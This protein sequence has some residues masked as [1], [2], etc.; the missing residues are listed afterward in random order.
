M[1]KFFAQRQSNLSYDSSEQD[2]LM[3]VFTAMLRQPTKDGGKK[4]EANA[5]EP[6]WRDPEHMAAV[7]SHFRRHE[8]GELVDPESG[9][10]P[11]VH[12][13]WRLLAIAF[14]ETYGQIDPG[15]RGVWEYLQENP[16]V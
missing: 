11:F 6:W 7:W 15:G 14:Q 13:A 4:R 8:R 2:V 12:A 9:A 5:K 1:G 16:R 10:H 3:E